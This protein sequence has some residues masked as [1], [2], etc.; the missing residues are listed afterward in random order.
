VAASALGLLAHSYS[1][2]GARDTRTL[3]T[4]FNRVIV[5]VLDEKHVRGCS[6]CAGPMVQTNGVM[7]CLECAN[8][9][10]L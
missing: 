5:A 1:G 8:Q 10:E 6:R 2:T 4:L 7:L 9:E 3:Q